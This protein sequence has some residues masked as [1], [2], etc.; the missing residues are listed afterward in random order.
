MPSFA[1]RDRLFMGDEIELKLELS[2]A[3]AARIVASKLFGEKAKVAEQVSTYFD[4]DKN[5]LAKAGL[6]LRIRRTG[7]MRVQTIKAGGG[8]S[9]GLF[10]RTEWERAVDDDTPVL[11]HATPLLTVIGG[12]AG[13]V[14]P[15]FIVKVE[16]CKWLVEDDGTTIEVVLDRG[17]VN[18]GDRSDTVCEI[19]LELK[20]GSP[21]ALFGLARKIDAI[22]PIRLGVLT[23]S[24]RGYRLAGP[25]LASVKAEPLALG[26]DIGAA[27]AFKQIVQSGIRQFRL[28]ED[29]LLSSRNP[30]AVHQARVAIRRMRSA[31]SVFR[32]MIGDDGADLCEELKWLAA[33]F[34]EA[35]DLDV[36]LERAPSGALRDRIA[37]VREKSYDHLIETLA[38]HRARIVMLNVAHWLE[39][40]RWTDGNGGEVDGDDLART[41][42]AKALAHLRRKVKRRGEG[43]ASADD[44]TRHE[45]RK[46]AKKLRYASEFFASL[47]DRKGEARR[48][49]RFVAALE[50]LQDRL[51]KLNDLATVPVLLTKLGIADQD[52]AAAFL[53]SETGKKEMLERA[54]R[55]HDELF[56]TKRFW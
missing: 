51:G 18:A 42:A 34:G 55:A 15:R 40:S 4:T 53:S 22:A 25:D 28:N 41:F 19:E 32:P 17:A 45:L 8:S 47:F 38:D 11:D 46:D 6:S 10:A 29:L 12:D 3:D 1:Q 49:R 31:F 2:P 44:E 20:A 23:K 26:T 13:K 7:N 27:A 50:E 24:E 43:L 30:D 16:R 54:K 37:A 52:G 36:L 39:Q 33:S 48:H 9:A 35:R 14:A 5:S 56:D 21:A